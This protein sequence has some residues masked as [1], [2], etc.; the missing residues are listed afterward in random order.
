MEIIFRYCLIRTLIGVGMLCANSC[1]P[2][3]KSSSSIQF[4]RNAVV[5]HRGAF[6]KNNFPENSIA[7][8]REAIRLGC[9]GSEFD[10]RMTA[11]DSLIINHDPQY[12]KLDI[13]KTNYADLLQYKLNDG[14]KLPTL[15]EYILAGINDNTATQLVCEIKP[16]EIDKERGKSIA[17]KTVNLIRSLKAEKRVTYISFDYDILK[18]IIAINPKA[19]TQYLNGEKSPEQLKA[20]DITGADYHFSVFKNKPEWI[21]SAKQLGITLNAWTVNSPDDIDWLIANDFNFI[22]TNEPELLFERL[23]QSPVASGWKLKWSDEFNNNGLPDSSKW[24]YEVGGH[25]WGNNELQYY[26]LSDTTNAM[27][28]NGLLSITAKK[29]TTGAN[30]YT[31]AKLIT[32]GKQ[33]FL[34]GKIDIS[35][36]LPAGR[37][38][39]PAIWMLGNNIDTTDWPTCGE[40]DIMEHV[41]YNKDSVFGSVHTQSFNHVI[42]TQTTKGITIPNLYSSFHVYS[43]EWSPEK[44]I[45]LVDDKQY[46][47]FFNQ[48]KTVNEWPFDKP[49]YLI[50]NLAIGGN[51][52]GQMGVDEN[53]FP[54]IMQVDYVRAYNK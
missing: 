28:K 38:T 23:K 31:S 53:I 27:V 15:R 36:K 21:A 30:N 35:A 45:F 2:V 5:A 51:W 20:D 26:T 11:D 7:S 10:V 50:L 13:E 6:K 33:L 47:E 8:L 17:E 48:H 3:K 24:N 34:Y 14:E 1:S 18:K 4:A 42:G 43:I 52:G 22:T 44:I 54:A 32:K 16:S 25:G 41:G 19:I 37:G 9:T 46:L 12:N 39:W 29:K 40:I 49:F